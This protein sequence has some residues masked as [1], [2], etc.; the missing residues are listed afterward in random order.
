MLMTVLVGTSLQCHGNTVL[1]DTCSKVGFA[2]F[3]KLLSRIAG[4]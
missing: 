2:T 1:N 4:W 3:V